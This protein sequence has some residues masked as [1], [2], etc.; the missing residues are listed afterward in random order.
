LG[1]F[2]ALFGP[3]LFIYKKSGEN[4][5]NILE[6]IENS[7][8]VYKKV[9]SGQGG[10]YQ[11]ACPYCGGTDRFSILP[12][13]DH[14]VCRGCKKAGDSIFF[15]MD[16]HK[17]TYMETCAH[18]GIRPEITFK[19]SRLSTESRTI[20]PWAPRK[21]ALPSFPWQEKAGAILFN[22]YKYLLSGHG[23]KHRDWLNARG[24]SDKTIKEARLGWCVRSLSFSPESW[25]ITS[26]EEKGAKKTNVWIPEGLIIP[27]FVDEKPVRLR[28]RQEN[29]IS[30]DRYI[31]VKGSSTGYLD[32]KAHV[33]DFPNADLPVVLCESELDGWLLHQEIGHLAS[34][35]SIG[36]AQ[37]RP[38]QVSHAAL[39]KSQVITIMDNDEAGAAEQGWW[40][41][42][43]P[44][45]SNWFMPAG[46]DP[47]EAYA[48]GIDIREWFQK[49]MGL[50]VQ[51]AD[52]EEAF[53]DDVPDINLFPKGEA[54]VIGVD[55][56]SPE[57]DKTVEAEVSKANEKLKIE[58]IKKV[59]KKT[60]N[61]DKFCLHNK[62]CY[63]KKDQICLKTKQS[64]W[65]MERCPKE[66]W[67][68]YHNSDVVTSIILGVGYGRK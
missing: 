58:N 5:M 11:G 27:Y 32:H 56:G 40:S 15:M 26:T 50:V 43:Y 6:T 10:E 1:N 17:K 29:P 51:E 64:V 2:G 37:A 62:F 38:D 53:W 47:G 30:D 66:Y 49:K 65:D 25:G 59:E 34:V 54:T 42:N 21:I 16:F 68:L 23:K 13:K 8:Y 48:F 14:F 61:E 52:G 22:A 44:G 3:G 46:K 57:G 12:E 20:I 63:S 41:K 55:S 36:N 67:Y 4:M 18:F 33:V 60:G 19:S 7:G 35:V 45:C 39:E 24:I 28:I 9:S 31:L